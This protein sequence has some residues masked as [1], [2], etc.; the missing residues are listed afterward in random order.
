MS[1]AYDRLLNEVC[2]RLGFCGSV[3]NGEPLHVDMLL[4][5][6]GTIS[7]SD[8]VDA[9]LKAEG[10]DPNDASAHQYRRSIRDAFIRHLGADKV[11]LQL[12]R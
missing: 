12:L 10:F 9:V 5:K 4:P 2:V 11:D 7:A 8:W 3:V 6:H 1:A